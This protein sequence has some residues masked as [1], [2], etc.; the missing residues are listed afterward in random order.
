[1][2]KLVAKHTP[3]PTVTLLSTAHAAFLDAQLPLTLR[4]TQPDGLAANKTIVVSGRATLTA[5]FSRP[6]VPLGAN[7]TT[8]PFTLNTT[9]PGNGRWVTT[10]LY[11][12]DPALAWPPDIQATL[13]WNTS[14]TSFDGVQLDAAASPASVRITSNPPSV[15][16]VAV[17]SAMAA[18]ATDGGWSAV[19]TDGAGYETPPDAKV[20]VTFSYPM[21][22]SMLQVHRAITSLLSTRASTPRT[23]C[24]A[25]A[26]CARHRR[27]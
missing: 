11:R 22:R 9:V 26:R 25:A 19:P 16:D 12:W 23:A 1:M 7:T 20:Q 27:P 4:W 21:S 24:S 17:T 2:V 6:V 18:N 8:V 14:L 15:V 10:Y 5:L 3:R 13:V